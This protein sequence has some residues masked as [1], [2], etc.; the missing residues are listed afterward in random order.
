MAGRL[1]PTATVALL[2]LGA[3]AVTARVHDVSAPLF[4]VVCCNAALD[5]VTATA[6][7][8][9]AEIAIGSTRGKP[10]TYKDCSSIG[11]GNLFSVKFR[12]Q[13][14]QFCRLRL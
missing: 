10:K 2:L 5:A 9:E 8:A 3:A 11:L 7:E 1:P 13:F 4:E 12:K 14:F 6:N